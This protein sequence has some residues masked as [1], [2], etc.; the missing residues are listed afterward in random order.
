[1]ILFEFLKKINVFRVNQVNQ[2]ALIDQINF[3]QTMHQIYQQFQH[4]QI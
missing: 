4:E 3:H 2:F 1:M